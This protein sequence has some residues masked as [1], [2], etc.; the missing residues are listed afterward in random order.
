MDSSE[1]FSSSVFDPAL[2]P[3]QTP[4]KRKPGVLFSGY[5]GR[6]VKLITHHPLPRLR[7]RGTT[8][9]LGA[10]FVMTCIGMNFN[11]KVKQDPLYV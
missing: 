1:I 11:D 3:I 5:S 2:R 9:A 7:I 10:C 4:V 6:G 8:N